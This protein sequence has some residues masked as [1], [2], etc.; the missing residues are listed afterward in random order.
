[1]LSKQLLA[2]RTTQKYAV[3][4]GTPI[5]ETSDLSSICPE[6]FMLPSL[7]VVTFYPGWASP[8]STTK[9]WGH[10]LKQTV[11]IRTLRRFKQQNQVETYVYASYVY[12]RF[13]LKVLREREP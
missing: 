13:T 12:F 4:I 3:S 7:A 1:M 10:V 6:R 5:T 8:C 11:I 2:N 9:K